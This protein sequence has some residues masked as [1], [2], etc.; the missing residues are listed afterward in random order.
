MVGFSMHPGVDEMG[1]LDVLTRVYACFL[2]G[3]RAIGKQPLGPWRVGPNTAKAAE[4][5][6]QQS[7]GQVQELNRACMH[8]SLPDWDLRR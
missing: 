4:H 6:V 7:P 2:F 3:C 5:L 1:A 8:I